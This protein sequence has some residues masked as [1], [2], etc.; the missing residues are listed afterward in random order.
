MKPVDPPQETTGV[1]NK[2]MCTE[3]EGKE[4]ES[5]QGKG[6]NVMI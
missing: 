6:M 5:G 1:E 2:L 4:R 3:E